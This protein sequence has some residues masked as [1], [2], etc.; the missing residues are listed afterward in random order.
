MRMQ[1]NSTGSPIQ[2]AIQN[3]YKVTH[4][5]NHTGHTTSPPKG[6]KNTLHFSMLKKANTF[7]L[8][9]LHYTGD[10]K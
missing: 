8:R 2:T 6:S 3:G 10:P 9:I 1:G 4:K 7:Y 5:V